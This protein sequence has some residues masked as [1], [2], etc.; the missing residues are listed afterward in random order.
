VILAC[1]HVGGQ[2]CSNP[3]TLAIDYALFLKFAN[4]RLAALNCRGMVRI[5]GRF[6]IPDLRDGSN[7][8]RLL[9]YIGL[10]AARYVVHESN[11]PTSI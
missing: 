7:L 2:I 1:L 9:F 6:P 10:P 4:R 5:F 3:A 11:L 8:H